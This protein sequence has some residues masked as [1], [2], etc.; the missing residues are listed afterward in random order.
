ME[1]YELIKNEFLALRNPEKAVVLSRFFKTGKGEYGEGDLFL[2]IVVPQTR[3][4]AKHFADVPL[5][6]VETLLNDSY[7]EIRLCALL[8][9]VLQFGKNKHNE[10]MRKTI[11]DF[12]LNHTDRINNWD[13]VDLTVRHIVGEYLVD[14]DRTLLYKLIDSPLLWE[15]R[16]AIVA[17]YAFIRRKELDDTFRLAERV[18]DHSHDLMQKATG[19]MLR[20]AGKRD[21][22]AL[23]RFL[24][25]HAAT[26]PRTTLRYALE[27]MSPD[28]RRY[29][30]E[31]KYQ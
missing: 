2:G 7:H 5:Q 3:A 21:R 22:D 11:F 15:Q 31:M 6:T 8:I 16:M 10:A 29:Y 27:K 25:R 17:T 18:I 14:K 1:Q 4:L 23:C 19:W 24:D 13:L 9:L 26:M 30:M 28:D 12:Y 20:E